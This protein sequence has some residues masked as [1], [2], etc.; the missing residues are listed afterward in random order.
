MFFLWVKIINI[1]KIN[2]INDIFEVIDNSELDGFSIIIERIGNAVSLIDDTTKTVIEENI[3]DTEEYLNIKDTADHVKINKKLNWIDK[4]NKIPRYVA[5]PL[6]P[7]NF[8]QTGKTCPKN[9]SRHDNWIS[10]GKY[11]CVIITGI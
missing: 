10:P 7:L 1:K 5:T 4:A 3:E 6:P 11:C 8:N 9:A 2:K